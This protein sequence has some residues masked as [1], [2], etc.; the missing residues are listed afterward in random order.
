MESSIHSRMVLLVA[1]VAVITA[2]AAMA[3]AFVGLYWLRILTSI[4]MFAAFTQ[5]INMMAGFIGYPAFGNVVFFGI[6]AYGTAVAMAKFHWPLPAALGAGLFA[7]AVSVVLFGPP[8]LRLRG[9]YFA[10]A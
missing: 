4:C 8:I 9:H 2:V 6:G 7:C 3:P 10:I 5:S 1:V